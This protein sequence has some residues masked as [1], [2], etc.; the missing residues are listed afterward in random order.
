MG[1]GVFG[2][3]SL[4]GNRKTA[5]HLATCVFLVENHI[6]DEDGDKEQER[7]QEKRQQ[8]FRS[9]PRMG[10]LITQHIPRVGNLTWPQSWIM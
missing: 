9:V 10:I 5:L 1:T 3:F 2:K 8:N 7:P 6:S 4:A